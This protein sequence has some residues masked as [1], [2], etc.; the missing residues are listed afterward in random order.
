[1]CQRQEELDVICLLRQQPTGEDGM[2]KEEEQEE[3]EQEQ[4]K[5]KKE[6]EEQE[7]EEQQQEEAPAQCGGED[8]PLV[9][10]KLLLD[11]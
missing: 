4:Y 3:E 11:C 9:Q 5:D 6:Q 2:V 7:Q 10:D 8:S 1:M